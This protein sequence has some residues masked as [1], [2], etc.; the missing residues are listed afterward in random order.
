[1]APAALRVL[2]CGKT[3]ELPNFIDLRGLLSFWLL[4]ELRHG[5]LNGAQL[6]DRL[7]WR[8]GQGVSPGTLYPALDHLTKQGL[9]TKERSGRETSF[10]LTTRGRNDLDC[11]LGCLE[12][13]FADV[14][15]ERRPTPSS[16]AR[17]ARSPA[18]SASG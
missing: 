13:M 17:R 16:G 11:A 18:R 5:T 14:M 10:A 15:A 2:C 8:R 7:E 9:V 4:W 1:M 3:C 12:A 6:A